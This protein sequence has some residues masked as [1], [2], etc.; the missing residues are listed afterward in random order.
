M[1]EI[2]VKLSKEEFKEKISKDFD[3]NLKDIDDNMLKFVINFIRAKGEVCEEYLELPLCSRNTLG[4]LIPKVY[5]FLNVKK[6]TWHLI[7]AIS[8]ILITQGIASTLLSM[9]GLTGQCISKLNE[10][11]GEVCVYFKAVSL[12]KNGKKNFKKE[13]ILKEKND[14]C[15]RPAFNCIYNKENE[16]ELTLKDLEKIFEILESKSVF[17]K[18]QS[19]E[20]MVEL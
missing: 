2:K 14:F 4:F 8:D 20:W 15:S 17:S 5:Y 7:G 11:N 13:D 12:K 3:I 10:Q 16:C 19:S 18:T 6:V 1:D 9:S